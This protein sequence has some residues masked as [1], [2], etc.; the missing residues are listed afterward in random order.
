MS[1][2]PR[3]SQTSSHSAHNLCHSDYSSPINLLKAKSSQ[4]RGNLKKATEYGLT[5]TL[6]KW[7][8]REENE[9]LLAAQFECIRWSQTK[10]FILLRQKA[11]DGVI[12]FVDL[13]NAM[14]CY[15]R[16]KDHDLQQWLQAKF[17][18]KSDKSAQQHNNINKGDAADDAEDEKQQQQ[19]Q[20]A[21]Q[22]EKHKVITLKALYQLLKVGWGEDNVRVSDRKALNGVIE[23]RIAPSKKKKEVNTFYQSVTYMFIVLHVSRYI[24]IYN[25][26]RTIA[27]QV[28]NCD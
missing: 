15:V 28:Y 6:A 13:L 2:T 19:K 21:E 27:K 9:Q 12:L 22:H 5:Q 25:C 7:R 24:Y 17:T 20:E 8:H 11:D 26:T 1:Q 14:E 3:R 18:L 10:G 23:F 4:L 16:N